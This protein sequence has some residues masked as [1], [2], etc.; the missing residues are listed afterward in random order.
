M[1]CFKFTTTKTSICQRK[2]IDLR[3]E[4][5]PQRVNRQLTSGQHK[6]PQRVV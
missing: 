4:Q 2:C 5:S 3:A 1:S 6:E